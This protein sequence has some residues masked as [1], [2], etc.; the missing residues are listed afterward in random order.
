MDADA[1][2]ARRTVIAEIGAVY[3][4]DFTSM[5]DRYLVAGDPD[6]VLARLRE[7]REAGAETVVFCPGGRGESRARQLGL[8]ADEVLP[9]L[10]SGG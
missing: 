10:H 6:S 7:Y 1:E 2:R 4:Q 3:Q 9:V 8:F 5:A